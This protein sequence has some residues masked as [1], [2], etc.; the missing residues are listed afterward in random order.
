[1]AGVKGRSGG[2]RPGAGRKPMATV[3]IAPEVARVVHGEPF[4]PRP[5]LEL[6]ALGHIDVSPQQYKALAALLP[7]TH[8]KK[9]EGKIK[10]AAPERPASAGKYTPRQPPRLVADGGRKL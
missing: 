1:M 7:Y 5:T 9:G 3:E 10:P 4:D 8:A 6:I 2:K